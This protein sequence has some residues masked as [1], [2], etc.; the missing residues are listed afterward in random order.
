M[1]RPSLTT[2]NFDTDSAMGVSILTD[3]RSVCTFASDEEVSE[4][5][6]MHRLYITQIPK[7]EICVYYSS[8]FSLVCTS[9]WL[10]ICVCGFMHRMCTVQ[11]Y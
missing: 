6:C 3:D 5:V 1:F 10:C 7:D 2:D 11:E 4:F 9:C 8:V